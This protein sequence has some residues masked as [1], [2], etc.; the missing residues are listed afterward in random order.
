MALDVTHRFVTERG[1]L[2]PDLRDT[3][4]VLGAMWGATR[5]WVD[6]IIR[7]ASAQL[8]TLLTE[9]ERSGGPMLVAGDTSRSVQDCSTN[10]PESV[11]GFDVVR[12]ALDRPVVER[13]GLSRASI[14]DRRT[15]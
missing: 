5:S 13:T 11:N 1:E 6:S 12:Q 3:T 10:S 2:W 4:G 7:T 15:A 14:F 9:R 8:D